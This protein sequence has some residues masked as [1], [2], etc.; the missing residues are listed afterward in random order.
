MTAA[1]EP[2]FHPITARCHDELAAAVLSESR[3]EKPKHGRI[4]RGVPRGTAARRTRCVRRA[5]SDE[6]ERGGAAGVHAGLVHLPPQTLQLC[7]YPGARVLPWIVGVSIDFNTASNVSE[8]LAE[9][10]V[11]EERTRRSVGR[12]C[13][14]R[15]RTPRN[16]GMMGARAQA[17]KSR[18]C[19]GGEG[20]GGARR[21]GA[22]RRA[23]G[24]STFDSFDLENPVAATLIDR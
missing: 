20:G 2:S 5:H 12:A 7:A 8:S 23:W 21:H 17:R 19:P 15:T 18:S 11:S 3:W 1:F 10:L 6:P 16:A 13:G 4:P 14:M 24:A 9:R 22:L